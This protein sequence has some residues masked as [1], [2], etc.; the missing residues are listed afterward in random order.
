M[1]V[2]EIIGTKSHR[3]KVSVKNALVC[4]NVLRLRDDEKRPK[5]KRVRKIN[6]Y[7]RVLPIKFFVGSHDKLVKA[8]AD[9]SSSLK[10]FSLKN[11]QVTDV[12]ER[13]G[14]NYFDF[15][16][17][18]MN[19]S[20]RY[21]LDDPSELLIDEVGRYSLQENHVIDLVKRPHLAILGQTSSGKSY[22]LM[23]LIYQYLAEGDT[24]L[25]I[26]PK[27]AELAKIAEMK[28]LVYSNFD[29]DMPTPIEVLDVA[30]AEMNKRQEEL[31]KI[32]KL[33]VN[34]IDD[35]GHKAF[36]L[37]IEEVSSAI[38]EMPKKTAEEF[39]KKLEVIARKGRSAGVYLTLVTQTFT[40]GSFGNAA[41]REQV[42]NI[43]AL[44]TTTATQRSMVFPTG[45]EIPEGSFK[46]EKGVGW[47]YFDGMSVFKV[48][49]PTFKTDL[50]QSL[51]ALPE[52]S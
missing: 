36:H 24:V 40:V 49:A 13:L 34:A 26:D 15:T 8:G 31:A 44:G 47:A 11:W 14:G 39:T 43:I 30:I 45:V 17:T 51:L 25:A 28:G 37:V 16:L 41:I 5:V 23:S 4:D 22:L 20:F 19:H 35:L 3:I 10:W 48:E 18:D 2:G 29:E 52:Q 12:Q 6:D 1:S 21:V 42:Q 50:Y 7:E 33:A 9:I 27:N 38:N 32:D 46:G